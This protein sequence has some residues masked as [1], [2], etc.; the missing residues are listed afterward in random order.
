M[1]A[2]VDV[3]LQG[4]AK[5]YFSNEEKQYLS[6][7]IRAQASQILGSQV[8]ILSQAK[9]KTLVKANSEG[10]SEAGC[11]AGF[12]KEIGVDL[13]MQPTVSY[14]FGRLNL[15]L[16]VADNKATIASRTLS[17]PPT[18]DGKNKLGV[19]AE[20]A[21]KEL[22][23]EV[24]AR[25]GLVQGGQQQ[26]SAKTV[27]EKPSVAPEQKAPEQ[28]VAAPI[29]QAAALPPNTMLDARDGQKYRTVKIGNQVWMAQNLNYNI[30]K[31]WCYD[32]QAS[33]CT[34]YGRLYDWETAKQT[35][36]SGWHLPSVNEW[37]NLFSTVG[38]SDVAGT[39]LKSRSDWD[40]AGI[41]FK[42]NGNGNDDFGFSALPAGEREG[43]E[44]WIGKGIHAR[45]WSSTERNST[46]VIDLYFLLQ[47][48]VCHGG[49]RR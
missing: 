1:M 24:A 42:E 35:C 12:I 19:D 33:N 5:K 39:K 41:I 20:S 25:L 46:N 37:G 16:E 17:G 7:A 36:P 15:T 28:K 29:P 10:C 27:V 4:E 14:A 31:S 48:P 47:S 49:W 8:E 38:G 11:F 3:Q 32:N 2:I 45:F 9:F 23:T 26:T 18:E 44:I 21:A 40:E 13:G 43:G 6:T 22:F 34:Q 30:G